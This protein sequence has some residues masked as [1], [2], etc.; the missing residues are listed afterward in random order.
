MDIWN[1]CKGKLKQ[2]MFPLLTIT[3]DG[4][5]SYNKKDYIDV[6]LKEDKKVKIPVFGDSPDKMLH[7][8]KGCGMLNIR[9]IPLNNNSNKLSSS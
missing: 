1:K 9:S 4:T 8:H 7:L 2:N 5:C 6:D 3:A